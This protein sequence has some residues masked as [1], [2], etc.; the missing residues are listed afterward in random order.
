[1]VRPDVGAYGF[2]VLDLE[3]GDIRAAVEEEWLAV[4]TIL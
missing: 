1:M 3:G 2:Y 4:T